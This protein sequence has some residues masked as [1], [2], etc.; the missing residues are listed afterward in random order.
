MSNNLEG[1]KDLRQKKSHITTLYSSMEHT[2]RISYIYRD[3]NM[4]ART[5]ENKAIG[6]HIIKFVMCEVPINYGKYLLHHCES[7]YFVL[8]T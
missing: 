5:W 6:M 4:P 3:I 7:A 2:E 8:R 1:G